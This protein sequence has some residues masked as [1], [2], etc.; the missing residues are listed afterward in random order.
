MK[1]DTNE[2]VRV[3]ELMEYHYDAS[4]PV[5]NIL[6]ANEKSKRKRVMT[7]GCDAAERKN[8]KRQSLKKKLRMKRRKELEK[9]VKEHQLRKS[10]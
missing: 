8:A 7:Q 6:A 4:T 1:K 3:S 9:L 5:H 2:V 10:S